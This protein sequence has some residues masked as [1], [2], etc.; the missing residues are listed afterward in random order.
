MGRPEDVPGGPLSSAHWP[1]QEAST[2]FNDVSSDC[3]PAVHWVRFDHSVPEPT[4]PGIWSEASKPKTWPAATAFCAC[5]WK[6]VAYSDV[7]QSLWADRCA[8]HCFA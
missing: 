6:G 4:A 7:G 8:D 3:W 2:F 1:G 5:D